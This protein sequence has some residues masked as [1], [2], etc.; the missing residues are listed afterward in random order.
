MFKK[1]DIVKINPHLT[2]DVP[3]TPETNLMVVD[4]LGEDILGIPIL[5]PSAPEDYILPQDA[6]N[7]RISSAPL[8]VRFKQFQYVPLSACDYLFSLKPKYHDLILRKIIFYFTEKHHESFH[9]HPAF[10]PGETYIRYAGRVYDEKEMIN[11][12]DA[13]LDFWLT[14]GRFAA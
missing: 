3:I 5:A 11:L 9:A 2:P 14:E 10:I 4:I 6:F 1:G 7:Q 8:A 12:M 13:G